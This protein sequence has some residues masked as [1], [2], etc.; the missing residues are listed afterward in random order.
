MS[1]SNF[2][3]IKVYFNKLVIGEN[4]V[5]LKKYLSLKMLINNFNEK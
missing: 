2:L 3:Q 5:L 4:K 1:S